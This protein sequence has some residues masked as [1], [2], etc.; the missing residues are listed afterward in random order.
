MNKQKVDYKVEFMDLQKKYDE[1]LKEIIE[2]HKSHNA[3]MSELIEMQEF[4]FKIIKLSNKEFQRIKENT[5]VYESK[6]EKA[7]A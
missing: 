6:T 4:V 5:P 7:N 2:D 3:Y 1:L